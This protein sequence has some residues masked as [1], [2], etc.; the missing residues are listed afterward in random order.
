MMTRTIGSAVKLR[1]DL[2]KTHG[3]GYWKISGKLGAIVAID[4]PDEDGEQVYGVKLGRN[5]FHTVTESMLVNA[6]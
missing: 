5:E 6:R 4:K 1:G 2:H 3:D